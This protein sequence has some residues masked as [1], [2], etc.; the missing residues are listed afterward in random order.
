MQR[1]EW[2]NS[3]NMSPNTPP[4]LLVRM[5]T[6][7]EFIDTIS[8][9]L[10][11]P[12]G[13]I[14]LNNG[15]LYIPQNGLWDHSMNLLDNSMAGLEVVDLATGET[16]VLI[17]GIVLGGGLQSLALDEENQILYLFVYR[18][19]TNAPV[20]PFDLKTNTAGE[21]LP[22][23]VDAFGGIKWDDV[24]KMLFIGERELNK[25]GL[26]VYNPAT[27]ETIKI[28]DDTKYPLPPYSQT[29]ERW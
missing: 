2:N 21:P 18:E 1:L 27:N 10:H 9:K 15:K 6:S 16:E 22:N 14:I 20:I 5:K 17:S 23:V 7:G 8:L 26:K 11:N 3:T 12:F 13:P 24:G 29:I 25:Y 4:G 28:R 19:W